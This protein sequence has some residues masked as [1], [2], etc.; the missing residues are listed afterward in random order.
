MTV[1]SNISQKYYPQLDG[2]RAFAIFLVLLQ[3]WL[4]ETHVL[5]K[6]IPDPGAMGVTLFFVLSGYLIGSI[7]LKEK[8][9]LEE[10]KTNQTKSS[11]LYKFYA[12]RT[13]RIFPIYYLFIFLLLII[14]YPPFI[15][16]LLPWLLTYTPNIYIAL[17]GFVKLFPLTH[18]W[19]LGVE[20]QFYLI[21]PLI[22]LSVP[23]KYL[24]HT[25][26]IF[27]STGIIFKAIFLALVPGHQF[28]TITIAQFDSFGIGILLGYCRINNISI[29]YENTLLILSLAT[30]ILLNISDYPFKG[31]KFL[32]NVI[33]SVQIC[34]VIIINRACNGFTKFGKLLLENNI[35]TYIGRISY[36][37]YVYHNIFPQ[38]NSYFYDTSKLPAE[39]LFILYLVELLIIASLSYYIIEKP[40]LSLKKYISY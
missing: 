21:M 29:P 32:Y 30:V 18:F 36:G 26:L 35:I 24:P 9:L 23:T 13:L 31:K 39:L 28:S 3:H 4:P 25:I 11:I 37:M 22:F 6:W 34:S 2:L 33:P 5:L 20:E 38:L 17:Y 15:K 8:Y 7:L 12:R 16:E 27:I 10:N 14:N 40:L 19:T 1:I